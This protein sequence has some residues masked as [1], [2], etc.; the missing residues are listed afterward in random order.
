MQCALREVRDEDLAVLFG[1]W[2]DPVATRMAAFT[3]PDH[4]DPD[5]FERRWSRLRADATVINRAIVVDG[6]VAGTIGSWG[7]PGQR[8]VTYWIGRS[9]WGRG[10]ATCALNAFLT[11]DRSR[12]LRARVAYDNVASQRVLEKCG[13]RVIATDRGFAGARSREIEEVVLR[14]EQA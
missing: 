2:A 13:F 14:L 4:M 7:D 11:V 1:Q 6:E 10:V 8:E 9:Y 3:A 5:A 12:P